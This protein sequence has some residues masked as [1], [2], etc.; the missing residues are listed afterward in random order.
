MPK[1]LACFE[2]NLIALPRLRSR[3]RFGNEPSVDE[4]FLKELLGLGN[5]GHTVLFQHQRVGPFTDKRLASSGA[6]W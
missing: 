5:Q 2:R 1:T 3:E 4:V 6:H